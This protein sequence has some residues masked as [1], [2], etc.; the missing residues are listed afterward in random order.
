MR[1]EAMRRQSHFEA[2]ITASAGSGLSCRHAL[3]DACAV[4]N[5]GNDMDKT[6]ISAAIDEVLREHKLKWG[7]GIKPADTTNSVVA[8]SISAKASA[9]ANHVK[10][11]NDEAAKVGYSLDWK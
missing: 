2:S 4:L 3:P 5:E 9:S 7:I 11:L 1:K 8:S 6:K 10:V